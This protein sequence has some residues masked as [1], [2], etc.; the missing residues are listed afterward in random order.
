MGKG[1][2]ILQVLE[3]E[4]VC[5]HGSKLQLSEAPVNQHRVV[6]VQCQQEFFASRSTFIGEAT[7]VSSVKRSIVLHITLHVVH[8]LIVLRMHELTGHVL[9]Q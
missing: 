2:L 5:L 3:A 9:F 8:T 4:D 1:K 6:H 7:F